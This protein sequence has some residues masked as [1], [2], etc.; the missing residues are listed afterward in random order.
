[1]RITI[2]HKALAAMDQIAKRDVRLGESP[3]S[4]SRGIG[5]KRAASNS[6][7]EHRLAAKK[8]LKYLWFEPFFV[9]KVERIHRPDRAL[10]N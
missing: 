7:A 10:G 3:D 2:P 4:V 5:T 8:G 6:F 9:I 1:M